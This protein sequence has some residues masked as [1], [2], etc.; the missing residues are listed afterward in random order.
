MRTSSAVFIGL[1][2]AAA[3]ALLA[4][5]INAD[6][7][8]Q[9]N[10]AIYTPALP[11]GDDTATESMTPPPALGAEIEDEDSGTVAYPDTNRETRDTES[12]LNDSDQDEEFNTTY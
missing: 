3:I 10:T 7:T 4:W 1:A 9:E 8:N 12:E 5:S 11:D 2:V 6:N